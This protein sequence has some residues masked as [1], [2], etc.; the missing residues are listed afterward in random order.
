MSMANVDFHNYVIG[1]LMQVEGFTAK[2][3]RLL[4]G[5]RLLWQMEIS[6]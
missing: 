2:T 1:S 5:R 3:I 4:I 6:R